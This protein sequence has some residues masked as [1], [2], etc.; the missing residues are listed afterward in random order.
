MPIPP[1]AWQAS[2]KSAATGVYVFSAIKAFDIISFFSRCL[3]FPNNR[4][5]AGVPIPLLAH[6]VGFNKRTNNLPRPLVR[7][8]IWCACTRDRPAV[9]A[10]V[11]RVNP[12]MSRSASRVSS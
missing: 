2:A 1:E 10:R 12:S 7:F 3:Y 8:K 11:A 4:V 9:G 6:A 5:S